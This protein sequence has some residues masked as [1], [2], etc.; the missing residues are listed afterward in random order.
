VL[1]VPG[2]VLGLDQP[3]A[4]ARREA[5]ALGIVGELG[6]GARVGRGSDVRLGAYVQVPYEESTGTRPNT[7]SCQS[8]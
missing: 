4:L 2:A 6:H 8:R 1:G 3:K 7:A 5:E